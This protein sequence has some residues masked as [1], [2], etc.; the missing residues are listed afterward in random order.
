MTYDLKKKNK[1]KIQ[2]TR[3]KGKITVQRENVHTFSVRKNSR[4][5]ILNIVFF[6]HCFFFL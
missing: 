4:K 2:K 3:K 6:N 5:R 1:T